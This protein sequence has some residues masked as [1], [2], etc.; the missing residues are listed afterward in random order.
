MNVPVYP[1]PVDPR[2]AMLV[3]AL[4]PCQREAFEERAAIIEYGSS[5]IS[6]KEAEVEALLEVLASS[7]PSPAARI[8]RLDSGGSS[9]WVL[10]ADPALVRVQ[11]QEVG[12][13]CITE[14]SLLDVLERQYNGLAFLSTGP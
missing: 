8:F 10:A 4:D 7:P 9:Q 3:D 14:E 2:V 12:G 1:T 11:L 6:R 13:G 5:G